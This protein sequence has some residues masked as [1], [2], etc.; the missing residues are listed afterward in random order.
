M[1]PMEL[2][3]PSEVLALRLCLV[4]ATAFFH[5][6]GL[7]VILAGFALQFHSHWVLASL[8]ATRGCGDKRGGKGVA[9]A[10]FA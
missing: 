8:A 3:V 4:H 6:Q 7:G 5:P 1:Q 2:C 9:G 10:A